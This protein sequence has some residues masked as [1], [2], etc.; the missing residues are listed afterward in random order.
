MSVICLVA[1]VLAAAACTSSAAPK[2]IT[3]VAPKP[4]TWVCSVTEPASHF[5]ESL[6]I[7]RGDLKT[8]NRNLDALF[9]IL[10]NPGGNPH[11]SPERRFTMD[12]G[13]V[14]P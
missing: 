6:F 9:G 10:P 8:V 4:P 7:A 5:S 1:V 12:C 13:T 11:G 2:A 3:T 14:R